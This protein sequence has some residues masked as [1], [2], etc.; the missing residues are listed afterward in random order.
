MVTLEEAEDPPMKVLSKA[1]MLG[2]VLA[3]SCAVVGTFT[4]TNARA[5]DSLPF[6]IDLT[7]DTAPEAANA[8]PESI[9]AAPA[10]PAPPE[11]PSQPDAST[12]PATPSSVEQPEAQAVP[13]QLAADA[14]R[15][16]EDSA[17]LADALIG[18]DADAIIPLLEQ[19]GWMLMARTPR[20]VQLNQ[21]QME[22]DIVVDGTTGEISDAELSDSI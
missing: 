6:D 12:T 16:T 17:Q 9:D 15:L 22:L 11:A 3:G 13:N 4:T 20:L 2:I 7:A 21:G 5:Q 8:T 14:Q 18:Q 1:S 10:M 19:N